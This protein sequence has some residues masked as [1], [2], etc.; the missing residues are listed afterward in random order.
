[1]PDAYIDDRVHFL[2]ADARTLNTATLLKYASEVTSDCR[3]AR[4]ESEEI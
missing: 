4:S 1:M 3:E 2:N